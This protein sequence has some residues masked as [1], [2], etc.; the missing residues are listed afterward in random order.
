MSPGGS[1]WLHCIVSFDKFREGDGKNVL[2]SIF[3]ANTS[4][5]HAVVVD[6]DIDY[7]IWNKWNGQ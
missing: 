3:A 5:K 4:I 2:M 7:M 6:S 1:G